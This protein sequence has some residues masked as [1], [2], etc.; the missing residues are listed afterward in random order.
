MSGGNPRREAS[1]TATAINHAVRLW[2]RRWEREM[3]Q[4]SHLG[5]WCALGNDF[6]D[7]GTDVTATQLPATVQ[8]HPLD[9]I[10]NRRGD[11]SVR[12][13]LSQRGKFIDRPR[14]ESIACSPQTEKSLQGLVARQLEWHHIVEASK[15]GLIYR[16]ALVGCRDENR[17]ALVGI[18]EL[19]EG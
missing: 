18:K 4:L 10:N 7:R 19:K 3:L 8:N 1:I 11:I 17:L 2:L 15:K 14:F 5:R 16:C 9:G 12:K 13:T 6:F